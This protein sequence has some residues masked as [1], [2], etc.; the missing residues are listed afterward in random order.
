MRGL[1]PI[2]N[3]KKY[4]SP[5]YTLTPK[6]GRFLMEIEAAK[7][8]IEALPLPLAI[9]EEL[10]RQARLRS[11]HF[12]TRIEGNRLTLAEA[13][14]VIE[15][16]RVIFKGRERDVNEVKNYWEALVR[17]ERWA[18]EHKPMTEELICK[19][20]ALVM[21]S[22]RAKPTPYREG[23][24][25]IREAG[26]GAL[27]YLP[28]EAKDLPLLMAGLVRWI[29][30]AER[31]GVPAPVIAGLA[32]YQFVTI[33]P[34]YD[35]NGRTAR[36]LATF[37]LHRSGYGLNGF[38]SL[39]ER[40]AQNLESYYGRLMT[41]PHHNYY[42]G[43]EKANLTQWV[44]YFLSVVADVFQGAKE[45]ALNLLRKGPKKQP[46]EF[47]TLDPRIRILLGHFIQADRIS[48][49]QIAK[50]LSLSDRMS[51]LLLQKWTREGIVKVLD[52]SNRKRA[53]G[54]SEKYRQFI[55]TVQNP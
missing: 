18:A 48:T 55:G 44:E 12:S 40:H 42:M 11:T 29:L 8:V 26:S 47:R 16:R 33:H 51:R 10:R 27:V 54:L 38:L 46:P 19:L 35:G 50:A 5:F 31:E 30:Q 1:I 13:Q 7:T 2:M 32:H 24:N 20:H 39:E 6:A 41:H 52:P 49:P 9:A 36:L 25:A 3:K 53:Y 28:P 21:E 4:W 23:Q 43:R 37:L 17:V 45:E 14:K 34:Y 22:P 15:G